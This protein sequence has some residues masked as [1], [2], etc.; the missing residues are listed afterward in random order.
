MVEQLHEEEAFLV[1]RRNCAHSANAL[2][3]YNPKPSLQGSSLLLFLPFVIVPSII[4]WPFAV[5][6]SSCKN[7]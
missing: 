7:S 3:G 2:T 1:L 4:C 5:Q 6:K